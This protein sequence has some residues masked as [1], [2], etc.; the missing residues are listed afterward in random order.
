MKWHPLESRIPNQKD[1]SEGKA[2]F[3]AKF[4]TEEAI[5]F[6]STDRFS[7]MPVFTLCFDSSLQ[8][9]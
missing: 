3:P 4:I 9:S 8:K 6:S 2:Q 7:S 5:D 1:T